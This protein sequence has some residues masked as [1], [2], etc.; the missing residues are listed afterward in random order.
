MRPSSP[1]AGFDPIS[2]AGLI[3]SCRKAAGGGP[4]HASSKPG[5]DPRVWLWQQLPSFRHL[6]ITPFPAKPPGI[7]LPWKCD[8]KPPV[9]SQLWLFAA[10]QPLVAGR[11][12]ILLPR[13]IPRTPRKQRVIWETTHPRVTGRLYHPPQHPS[14]SILL[15]GP[16]LPLLHHIKPHPC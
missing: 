3:K 6:P 4:N 12:F 11:C 15:L 2:S 1:I 16:C 9:S 5:S 10:V 7:F 8:F 14:L 13:P